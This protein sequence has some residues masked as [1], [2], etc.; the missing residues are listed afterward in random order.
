MKKYLNNNHG[1]TLI[2]MMIVLTIISILLLIIVPN[3]TKNTEVVNGKSCDATIKLL[4]AQVGVYEVEKGKKPTKV[5]DLSDYVDGAV[6]CPDNSTLV[7]ENGIVK[8]AGS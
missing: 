2:E 6:K 7:I 1:F 5:E 8:K 4:Q 3:M